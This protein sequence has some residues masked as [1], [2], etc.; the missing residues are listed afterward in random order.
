MEVIALLLV[1]TVM[2][3]KAHQMYILWLE[4]MR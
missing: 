2:S 1:L 4:L 3:W